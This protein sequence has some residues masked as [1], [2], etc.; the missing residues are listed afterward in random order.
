M[1]FL[2]ACTRAPDSSR[3]GSG[4]GTVQAR[5]SIA[6]S[7]STPQQHGVGRGLRQNTPSTFL[8]GNTSPGNTISPAL[9]AAFVVVALFAFVLVFSAC[10]VWFIIERRK[11][12]NARKRFLKVRNEARAPAAK[13]DVSVQCDRLEV[14]AI[15]H[16]K[17]LLL[18]S[19][20]PI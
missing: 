17:L 6:T 10:I 20:E 16:C 18:S 9:F 14:R 8:M 5:A 13:S 1:Q 12:N 11:L 15:S 4:T 19:A 7:S 2:V 3:D